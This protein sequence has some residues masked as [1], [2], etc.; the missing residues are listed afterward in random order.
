MATFKA[1]VFPA[2]NHL[3][4][5]GTT[6]IKIRVY[7]KEKAQYLSTDFYILPGH[8]GKNGEVSPDCEEGDMLNY[9]LG[10]IIQNYRKRSIQLGN[11][12]LSRMTCK[13]LKN[14]LA[15]ASQPDYELTDFVT[16][17]REVIAKTKKKNTINWYTVAINSLVWF[18]GKEVIDI[19][20]V[21]SSK[22][23]SYIETLFES[24]GQNQKPFE[25]GAVNNYMRALRSLFNKCKLNYNDDNLDIIRIQHDPFAKVKIPSVRRKKKISALMN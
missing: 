7:H 3:K 16:F 8:M 10:E 13:D 14:Y 23:Q 25:P 4:S 18:Y 17:S 20:E 22:L 19:K 12:R 24:G 11:K 5:D 21:T 1:I 2:K 6:N 9:E 15:A